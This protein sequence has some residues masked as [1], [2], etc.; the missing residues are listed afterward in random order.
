MCSPCFAVASISFLIESVGLLLSSVSDIYNFLIGDNQGQQRM[1]RS[2]SDTMWL[3]RP[4]GNESTDA[5]LH[6][7]LS[8]IDTTVLLFFS[9][10]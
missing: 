10:I 3:G 4:I 5:T 8:Y 7:V 2:S 1:R 6:R 9:C